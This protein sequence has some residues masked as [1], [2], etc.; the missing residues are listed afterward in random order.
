[1]MRY[2][3]KSKRTGLAPLEASRQRR[4]PHLWCRLLTGFSLL[5]IMVLFPVGLRASKMAENDTKSA[6]L[7]QQV[8]EWL[9]TY[10]YDKIDAATPSDGELTGGCADPRSGIQDEF[11]WVWTEDAV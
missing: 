4:L 8:L 6:L 5:E 1:M 7:G 9:R 3:A 10:T 11:N 2:S